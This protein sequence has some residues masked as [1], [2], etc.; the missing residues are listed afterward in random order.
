LDEV[1][2]PAIVPRVPKEVV[3]AGNIPTVKVLAQGTVEDV[4][5]VVADL[6][7]GM[8]DI[9]TFLCMPGCEVPTEATLENLRAMIDESQKYAKKQS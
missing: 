4:R 7:E 9:P 6:C 3:I 8:R 5:R 2:M 1:D